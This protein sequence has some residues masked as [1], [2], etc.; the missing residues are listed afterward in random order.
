MNGVNFLV[1]D[2]LQTGMQ[3]GHALDIHRAVFKAIG[4]FIEVP[5]L[6]RFDSSTTGAGMSDLNSFPDTQTANTGWSQQRFMAGKGHD[7]NI[8]SLHID[9]HLA[10]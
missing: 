3:S 10:G 2:P 6:G 1:E 5:V 9:E 8:H 7:I 4:I